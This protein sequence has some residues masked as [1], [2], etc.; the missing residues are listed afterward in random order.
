[1]SLQCFK[2]QTE[3][4]FEKGHVT[5]RQDTCPKCYQDIKCCKMCVFY[6]VNSYNEC[7][8]T[9]ADRIKEKDKS[10]FCD[11]FKISDRKSEDESANIVLSAAEALFKK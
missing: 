9:S 10:N 11:F 2:C 6:D 3:I 8:E 4:I 5:S 1:M 7:R